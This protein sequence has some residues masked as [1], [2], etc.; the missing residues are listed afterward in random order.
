MKNV[1]LQVLRRI[2]TREF[3]SNI[4]EKFLLKKISFPPSSASS[5]IS[6]DFAKESDEPFLA[7]MDASDNKKSTSNNTNDPEMDISKRDVSKSFETENSFEKTKAKTRVLETELEGQY[8][9]HWFQCRR[10]EIA[11]LMKKER[12]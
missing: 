5:Q 12:T 7:E 10:I 8:R 1:I 6:K 9:V 4:L 3:W 11:M 2:F